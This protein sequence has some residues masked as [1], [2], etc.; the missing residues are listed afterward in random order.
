MSPGL[1]DRDALTVVGGLELGRRDVAVL[2]DLTVETALVEPVDVA[3]RGELDVVEA[4]PGTVA[5]DQLPLV[6]AVERR[7]DL[8]SMPEP[9]GDTMRVRSPESGSVLPRCAHDCTR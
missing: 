8:P 9:P 7:P 3:E 1:D 6:E 5:I 2:G 4:P